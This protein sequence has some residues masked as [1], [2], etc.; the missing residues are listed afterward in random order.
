MVVAK[1]FQ[2]VDMSPGSSS[3]LPPSSLS[4]IVSASPTQLD[5]IDIAGNLQRYFGIFNLSDIS[6]QKYDTS[7]FT[8]YQ[9]YSTNIADPTKLVYELSGASVNGQVIAGFLAAGDGYALVGEIFKAGDQITGS[10]EN[11]ILD[12]FSGADTVK[13]SLGNDT[14]SGSQGPD[15]LNGNEG[16]DAVGGGAGADTVRGGKG[17]DVVTGGLDDDKVYGDSGNDFV[18]GNEGNDSVFGGDGNDT[19]RGEIGDDR[20]TGNA[21]NDQ[22]FGDLGADVFV[23]SKDQDLILDF[24]ASEGDK[25]EV[26]ASTPYTL[27]STGSEGTGDLQIIRDVGITTLVGV[28]LSSFD[29]A[30]SIIPI[31]D[32][33]V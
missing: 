27:G 22:L 21:G 25:I 9:Q 20:I 5:V 6:K 28:S 24:D 19:L 4:S 26:L 23:L 15:F 31:P 29:A 11:D 12:G 14:I 17:N 30:T 8:G 3:Y 18:N 13:G 32:P 1:A 10:N 7:T 16:D 2:S 33:V